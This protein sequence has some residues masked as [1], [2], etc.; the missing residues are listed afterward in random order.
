[1]KTREVRGAQG[2]LD[3]DRVVHEPARLA[4][5]TV[6][7]AAEEVEFRYLESTLGL[8]QGNLS[9]HMSRLE[10]AGYVAVKKG[11]RGKVPVTWLRI[12][13]PGT[14]ALEDYRRRIRGALR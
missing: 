5:L 11:Y 10:S 13:R 3:V 4:I 1:M 2:L 14:R 9:A 6:L 8:T 12:T 7:A